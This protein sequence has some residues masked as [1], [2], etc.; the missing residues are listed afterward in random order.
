M[1]DQRKYDPSLV[2]A[3]EEKEFH[4]DKDGLDVLV[5][6]VPDDDRPH[7]MDPRLYEIAA[8]KKTMFANRAKGGFRLSNERYR[9]DK[10]TYELTTV[11]IACEE[12][13]IDVDHDHMIDLYIYRREDDEGKVLPLMIYLHGGGFTAGNIHL[14][15]KQMRLVAELGHVC[16]MFPEY[17]LAPETPY[18]GAIHDC[19]AAVEYMYDHAEELHID[20]QKIMVAGDS[21]GGNLTNCCVLLDNRRIIR[22]IFELYPVWDQRKLKDISEYT[23]SYDFYPMNKDQKDVIVSRI[24]RIK[25]GSETDDDTLD[26]YRYGKVSEKDPMIS[27]YLAGDEALS[28]FPE[29]VICT[30]EFDYLRLQGEAAARKL[31]KLGVKTRYVEY[32]GC[33]HGFLDCLGRVAQAEEACRFM[34]REAQF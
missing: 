15:E 23:W 4:M 25:K 22:K 2:D 11:P 18:P 12:R 5:K 14:Y 3:M 21:A 34:A 17:R 13:L 20:P 32:A 9:P 19:H 10:V 30:S 24:E 33:D 16:V 6:P 26:L 1:E 27:A 31:Q 8:K 29:T 7:V 28:R